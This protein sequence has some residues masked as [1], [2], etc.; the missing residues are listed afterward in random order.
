MSFFGFL[1]RRKK[2]ELPAERR[3]RLLAKGRITDGVIIDSDTL[4][5]GTEVVQYSYHI[6]GVQF[7]SSEALTEEQKAAGIKYAPGASVAI[8]FDPQNQGNSVLV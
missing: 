5:D 1:G 3:K 8:R 4:D 6:H 2:A 7:E